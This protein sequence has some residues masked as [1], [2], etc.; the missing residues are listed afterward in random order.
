MTDSRRFHP[1]LH[2]IALSLVLSLVVLSMGCPS[3]DPVA[4]D[5][6][7]SLDADCPSDQFCSSQGECTQECTQGEDSGCGDTEVCSAR[8][9]C[10]V[11]DGCSDAAECDAPPAA[12]TPVCEGS[13]SVLAQSIGQ[14][15]EAPEGAA[16]MCVYVDERTECEEGCD[17][18]NGVLHP[19]L[20]R[21][22]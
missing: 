19:H 2:T 18:S 4:D 10:V 13:A 15:V 9:E 12:G 16:K 17:P 6:L 14:C 11:V 7:C 1:L 3:D 5:V 21:P 8:S 22:M 20:P